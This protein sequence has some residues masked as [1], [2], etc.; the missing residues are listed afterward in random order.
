MTWQLTCNNKTFISKLEAIKESNNSSK[1][2]SFNIP[3]VYKN[4]NCHIEPTKSM[5]ELCI[6]EAKNLRNKYENVVLFYSGGCD[7]HY[8]LQTFLDNN[9]KI[10][11]I[12]MVKSG[13][14][15]SDFEINE[16]ALPFVIKTAIPYEVRSPDID[17]YKETYTREFKSKTQHDQ[18]FHFRLNNDF[19][20]VANTDTKQVNIFGKEKP[21][22][23]YVNNKWYTY[24][25]DVDVTP[26]PKQYNFYLENPNIHIKQCHMLM[27]NII[28][29]KSQKEF[30]KITFFD[31]HQDFWN[32]SIGRYN[33]G[34]FPM[35]RLEYDGYYNNKDQLAIKNAPNELVELWKSRNKKLIDTY[36]TKW[37]NQGN[38]GLGTVGVFSNFMCL[39]EKGTKSIDEL[40]P[41]GFLV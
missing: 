5:A 34:N 17:Y 12:I 8:I 9:I 21:K 14:K 38:P 13:F 28:K 40:F 16:T 10:D 31:E 1:P 19:E 26:Q 25:L 32:R 7:S 22:L 2:I 4:F 33:S 24:F 3:S 27:Q 41:K 15:V 11:K 30:N 6:T 35:K 36:G 37:F 20:N 23:V 29:N 39:S 18:W